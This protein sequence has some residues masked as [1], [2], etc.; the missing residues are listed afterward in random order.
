MNKIEKKAHDVFL[1]KFPTAQDIVLLEKTIEGQVGNRWETVDIS[2][3]FMSEIVEWETRIFRKKRLLSSLYLN[4]CLICKRFYMTIAMEATEEEEKELIA[5]ARS[6]LKK[7]PIE[8]ATCAQC[9]GDLRTDEDYE[10]VIYLG[11][12]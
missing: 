1:E 10:G 11:A 9:D 12:I 2:A 8:D 3:D 7:Y 4:K 6:Q 5:V